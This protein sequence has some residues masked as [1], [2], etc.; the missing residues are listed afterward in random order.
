MYNI[1]NLVSESLNR[2]FDT[3]KYSGYIK[4][5]DVYKLV[6]STFILDILDGEFGDL[7]SEEDY[8]A[9]DN[10]LHCFYGSSCLIPY[11]TY[12]Q[13]TVISKEYMSSIP[14]IDDASIMK[15]SEGNI[16]RLVLL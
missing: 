6:V 14:F 13:N 16:N 15:F 12:K 11:P 8:K 2:Y 4:Y 7:I 5:K 1:N 10:V 9:M 3:L